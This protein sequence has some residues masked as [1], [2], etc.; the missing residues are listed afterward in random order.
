MIKFENT[1]VYGFETAIRG[2][3]NPLN[4]WAKS[5][6]TKPDWCNLDGSKPPYQIGDRDMELMTKLVKAGDEHA[7][8][9]R[10]ITVTVDITA[11][12]YWMSELDT[13]KVGVV[14]NSC[15]FMHKG[16]SKPFSVGDFDHRGIEPETFDYVVGVLNTLRDEYLQTKDETLFQEIRCLLPSGYLQR[17]TFQFNY[18]V[19][20]NIYRQR[21][22]HRLPEWHEFC[23]W[24]E[25]LPYS[26]LITEEIK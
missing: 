5:D 15:S 13:Y 17:S 25:G 3:R 9:M 2:M 20:R 22:N 8:F 6:S 10:M 21:K 16:V 4:S 1:E 24:I 7:K 11:P 14:R 12:L 26:N 19:L 23:H 18:A